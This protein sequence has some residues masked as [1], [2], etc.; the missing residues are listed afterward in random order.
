M[1]SR[2]GPERLEEEPEAEEVAELP[3]ATPT[4]PDASM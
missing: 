2:I 3:D 1:T 4:L